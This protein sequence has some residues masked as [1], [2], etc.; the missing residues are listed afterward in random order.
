MSEKY[1]NKINMEKIKIL[2]ILPNNQ[3]P[4]GEI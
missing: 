3:E 2:A 1:K 4:Q